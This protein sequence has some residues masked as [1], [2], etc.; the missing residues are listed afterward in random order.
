MAGRKKGDKVNINEILEKTNAYAKIARAGSGAQTPSSQLSQPVYPTSTAQDPTVSVV[1]K[2]TDIVDPD[3]Y[4]TREFVET[5]RDYSPEDIAFALRSHPNAIEVVD[6]LYDAGIISSKAVQDM[7]SKI[8][9]PES[10]DE[11]IRRVVEEAHADRSAAMAMK[12]EASKK[13]IAAR[14]KLE[15]VNAQEVE[16]ARVEQQLKAQKDELDSRSQSIEDR[17]NELLNNYENFKKT[18][19]EVTVQKSTYDE[20]E[21]KFETYKR[22]K[23]IVINHDM[24]EARGLEENLRSRESELKAEE[25]SIAEQRK[26]LAADL[27]VYELNHKSLQDRE[28]QLNKEKDEVVKEHEA[29]KMERMSAETERTGAAQMMKDHQDMIGDFRQYEMKMFR[30]LDEVWFEKMYDHGVEVPDAGDIKIQGAKALDG[31]TCGPISMRKADSEEDIKEAF[32]KDMYCE[33]LSKALW[34]ASK[35]QTVI[36]ELD[37]KDI[38]AIENEL[39]RDIY[40]YF[41]EGGSARRVYELYTNLKLKEAKHT[42]EEKYGELEATLKEKEAKITAEESELRGQIERFETDSETLEKEKKQFNDLKTEELKK[43][44][45]DG[46]NLKDFQREF[47]QEKVRLHDLEIELTKRQ[48]S[49]ETERNALTA[50]QAEMAK[51]KDEFDERERK[52]SSMAREVKDKEDVLKEEHDEAY[53]LRFSLDEQ[54]NALKYQE[55]ELKKKEDKIK[56][57]EDAAAKKFNESK[58]EASRLRVL[59]GELGQLKAELDLKVH[60]IASRSIQVEDQMKKVSERNEALEEEEAELKNKEAEIQT[61]AKGLNDHESDLNAKEEKV[62]ADEVKLKDYEAHLKVYDKDL[63]AREEKVEKVEAFIK[64]R[65]RQAQERKAQQAQPKR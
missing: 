43:L 44:E 11:E 33:S 21:R 9:S 14:K 6:I 60:Q 56:K 24:N 41:L 5:L 7:E 2:T 45:A 65:A 32:E 10:P 55:E 4:M 12:T 19:E 22:E 37:G 26:Q 50:Q 3:E 23:E 17:E 16:L 13:E 58:N 39:Q 31:Q 15:L 36:K 38:E 51:K 54:Q 46:T 20:K 27:T 47:E 30:V 29:A 25:A 8:M 18:A 28:V 59:E 48:A 49:L 40:I 35:G 53:N 61:K 52:I 63:K 57:V 34:H 62:K 64:E 1:N 42:Y